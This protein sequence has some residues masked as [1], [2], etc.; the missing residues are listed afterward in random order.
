MESPTVRKKKKKKTNAEIEAE[1]SAQQIQPK[2]YHEKVKKSGQV[3]TRQ[4]TKR[5][6]MK[7]IE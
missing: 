7:S 2:K 6:G 5:E 4:G 3:Y 1:V